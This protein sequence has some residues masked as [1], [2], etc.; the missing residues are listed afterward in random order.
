MSKRGDRES[1]AD[2]HEAIQRIQQYTTGLSYSQFLADAKTQDAVVRNVEILG[3]AVKHLSR[4][5]TAAHTEVEWKS[6]AGMR[7]R[8]V[9]EYFGVNLDILWDVLA[10]KLPILR[11]QI[12]RITQTEP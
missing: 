9:H 11:V 10:T 5:L 6:I 7:D 1:L 12:E 2:M 8:L 3:E 4:E